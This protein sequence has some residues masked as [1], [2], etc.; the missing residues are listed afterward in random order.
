M[1]KRKKETHSKWSYV[2][3]QIDSMI[4]SIYRRRKEEKDQGLH[5]RIDLG[6]K[7]KKDKE[8]GNQY[9]IQ[10]GIEKN[11]GR[12]VKEKEKLTPNGLISNRQS[13]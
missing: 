3:Q 12:C 7:Q 11:K 9:E 6:I 8:R 1:R 2:K 4:K 13:Q 5:E 10:L